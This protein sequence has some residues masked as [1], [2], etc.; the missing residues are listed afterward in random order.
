M[1]KVFNQQLFRSW[2]A[3]NPVPAG[4]SVIGL[5]TCCPFNLSRRRGVRSVAK[6]GM[7]AIS[8]FIFFEITRMAARLIPKQCPST[9]LAGQEMAKFCLQFPLISADNQP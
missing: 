1:A 4:K 6:L 9:G 8:F 5:Q 2:Q 3:I 7:N